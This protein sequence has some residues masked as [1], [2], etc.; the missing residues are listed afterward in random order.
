[1]LYLTDG[2]DGRLYSSWL[3]DTIGARLWFAPH[4]PH[5]S[6][7]VPFYVGVSNSLLYHCNVT[8]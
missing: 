6:A 4:Q 5:T 8:H 7:F 3:P 1:V 2:N